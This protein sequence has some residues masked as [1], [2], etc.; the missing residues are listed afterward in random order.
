MWKPRVNDKVLVRTQ[1][2]SD[3]I[4]G[5]TG[6]FIRPYEGPYM[7]GKVLPPSTVE[8]CDRNGK[9]KSQ[10]NWKLIKVYKEGNDMI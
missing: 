1:P 7:I 10:F 4:V 8:V 5:V 3:A 9:F 6:K 2:C